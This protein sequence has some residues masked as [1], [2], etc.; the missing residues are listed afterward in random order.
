MSTGSGFEAAPTGMEPSAMPEIE[1]PS[2]ESATTGPDLLAVGSPAARFANLT[3]S[4]AS[5]KPI[6]S[7]GKLQYSSW[8]SDSPSTESGSGH[9]SSERNSCPEVPA[10]CRF[11]CSAAAVS[12]ASSNVSSFER[13]CY[14]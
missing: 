11:G 3:D 9:S 4:V 12:F 5:A 10:R 2:T 8:S 13:N 6:E 1:E 7:E 14:P